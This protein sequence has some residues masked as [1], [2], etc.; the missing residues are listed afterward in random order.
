Q[1]LA[2]D[3]LDQR[4]LRLRETVD[5]TNNRRHAR[6]PRH[7]RGPPAALAGDELIALGI[8]GRSPDNNWL[9]HAG[10]SDARR[11]LR[12]R[13]VVNRPSRLM[14]IRRDAIKRD[15]PPRAACRLAPSSGPVT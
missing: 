7:F 13:S 10:R 3:V 5:I 11:Q 12:D 6:Q 8:V 14:W 15:L 2:L 4:H 1:V 9:N